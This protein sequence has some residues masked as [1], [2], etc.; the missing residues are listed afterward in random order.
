M[1]PI[2]VLSLGAGIQ[3]SA[4]LLMSCDGFLPKLDHAIFA[5]T[6]WEPAAVYRH[7]EWLKE[8][9]SAAGIPLHIVSVGNI[10]TDMEEARTSGGA[11]KGR[12][13]S[14][15]LFVRGDGIEGMIRRQCTKEYKIEPI[16]KKLRQLLGY[17]PRKRIKPGSVIQW[18][19]ISTD[20]ARRARVSDKPWLD[21]HYPLILDLKYSRGDCIAWLDKHYPDREVVR[22]ACI[23]C[24]FQSD[25]QWK[26]CKQNQPAEF[27]QAVEFDKVIRTAS[28]MIADSFLHRSRQPLDQVDFNETQGDMFEDE[29]AGVCGV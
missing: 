12:W 28:G 22:S 3:S 27:A 13:A 16:E 23:G 6:G 26:D 10:K 4:L 19:G 9:S 29:C 7:L 25:R 24:P 17:A 1:K 15:P 5:D 20:E 2:K 11:Y 8:K 14:M 21:F 18:L